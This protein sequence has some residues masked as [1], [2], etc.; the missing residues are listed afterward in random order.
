MD[1]DVRFARRVWFRKTASPSI[2]I[3]LAGRINVKQEPNQPMQFFGQVEP[4]P[5]RGEMNLYGRT[6][7]LEE[8]SI[9]LQGPAEATTLD[10]T[11][12]YQVPTQG[13]PDDEEV[14]IN[15]SAKGRPDS[16]A[17]DFTSEPSMAEEDIISYIVTG[18]PASD[19]PLVDQQG[20]GGVQRVAA[21]DQ[22]AGG[23]PRRRRG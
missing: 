3:E 12:Q 2:D 14:L 8:G 16:L 4:I 15:V 21:R 7:P 6:L 23:E 22:P 11:A 13:D 18:R 9:A 19:N 20:G 10:V 1:L 17:L 5:R